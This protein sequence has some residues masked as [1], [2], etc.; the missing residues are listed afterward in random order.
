MN[1]KKQLY[2]VKNQYESL[3]ITWMRMHYLQLIIIIMNCINKLEINTNYYE[4]FRIIMKC[5]DLIMN[6]TELLRI[7]MN[8]ADLNLDY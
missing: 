7:I 2:I 5:N 8:Y 4:L 3:V 1:Y 6:Y